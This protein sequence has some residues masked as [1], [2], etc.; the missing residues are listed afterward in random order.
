MLVSHPWTRYALSMIRLMLSLALCFAALGC[1]DKKEKTQTAPEA[2][3]PAAGQP[4]ATKKGPPCKSN[5]DCNSGWFCLDGE[6]ASAKSKTVYTDP[7]RAVTP[8]KVKRELERVNRKREADI[9]K[10]LDL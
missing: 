3:Q 4:E 10:S 1:G 6:C 7:A 5:A 9:D 8:D 2:S